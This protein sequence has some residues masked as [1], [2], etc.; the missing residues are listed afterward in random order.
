M[1][2][3]ISVLTAKVARLD[4]P[5]GWPELIPTV[6]QA[7]R[8]DD[9]LVQGRALLTLHHVTKMLASKRL[10]ADRKMFEDVSVM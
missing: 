5:R 10:A 7:V 6:L 4:C 1:A 2:T 8:C 9:Q 3:Q